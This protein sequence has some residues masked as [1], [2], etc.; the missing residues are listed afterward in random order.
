MNERT[1]TVVKVHYVLIFESLG[2]L[3]VNLVNKLYKLIEVILVFA[4]LRLY[5]LC[6][7]AVKLFKAA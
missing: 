6:G 1:V 2:K 7:E 5:L 3:S 4:K